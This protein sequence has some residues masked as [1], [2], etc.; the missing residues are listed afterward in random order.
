MPPFKWHTT[1][2][3]TKNNLYIQLKWKPD[4]AFYSCINN[5][6]LAWRGS[7]CPVSLW[8][9]FKLHSSMSPFVEAT[10]KPFSTMAATT[11]GNS[12]DNGSCKFWNAQKLSVHTSNLHYLV[13]LRWGAAESHSRTDLVNLLQTEQASV[14]LTNTVPHLCIYSVQI[15]KQLSRNSPMSNSCYYNVDVREG[16]HGGICGIVFAREL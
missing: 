11:Q 14:T 16:C 7:W 6:F 5:K 2:K 4:A 3:S 13:V 10:P 9:T 1:E 12:S 15:S 8:H